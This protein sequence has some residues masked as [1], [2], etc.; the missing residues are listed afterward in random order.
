MAH[1]GVTLE[2]TSLIGLLRAR[3]ATA[4]DRLAYGIL[5]DRQSD[6]VEAGVT[7]AEIDADARRIAG[8]LQ[9]SCGRG[10]RA[11]L[12]LPPGLPFLRAFFGTIY[13]GLIPIPAPAPEFSRRKRTLPRLQSIVR[14]AEVS[15]VVSTG[16]TLE[17]LQRIRDDVPELAGV[18]LVDTDTAQEAAARDWRDPG[19][20]RGDI[21]YLQYTSGSTKS[22]KGVI[23][24][25][26]NVLDHCKN[27]RAAAGY[28]ATS[29]TITWMPHFH[30]YGLVEGLILPL[31]NATPAHV[32]SPFAFLKR[33]FAWLDAIGRLRGTHTQAPNF[34]FDQCVRRIRPE[35][36]ALLDLSSLVAMGNA[37]EP[38]NPEVVDQFV[39]AFAPSGLRPEAMCPAYGLAE[40]TLIVS[41]SRIDQ[42]PRC[43]DFDAAELGRNRA[44]PARGTG[45]SRR[46]VSCG[47]A[48]P[49]TEIAIVDPESLRAA[50]QVAS[51]RSGSPRRAWRRAIGN[52]PK[53]AK[54]LSGRGS[55]AA[56]K[57]HSCAP[58]IWAF[59]TKASFS[60]AAASR[61]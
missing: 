37:A 14:D 36:R 40:A 26:A 54:Q 15:L 3:A 45:S 1:D 31:Q 4:P 28:D 39:A 27:L 59:C 18:N 60:S 20:T 7:Y 41:H 21:A 51:A 5:S 61:T 52:C 22:P 35:Q 57:G 30:D 9:Q 29:V 11:L 10:E 13:A 33:P 56:A 50:R 32:M 55:P 2:D 58:A 42:P 34:A 47:A 12:L 16:E 48:I 24:T 23:L 44:V 43:L 46:I 19:M 17:L 25:H 38:I 49:S 8:W 53:R 6:G